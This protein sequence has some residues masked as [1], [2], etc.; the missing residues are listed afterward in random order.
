MKKV[1]RNGQVAV[2]YSP[3]YGAGW[4]SWN[5]HIGKDLIFDPDLVEAIEK[6]KDPTPIAE[7]KYPEA[8]HGGCISL[9]IEWVPE[10]SQ[11]DIRE[12][13]GSE[14]VRIL[15]PDDGITA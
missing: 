5:Q 3:G 14:S 15:S 11:F 1:V 6:G 10:G 12:Y 2:L 8:Y 7:K 13:D 9:E 4:Y